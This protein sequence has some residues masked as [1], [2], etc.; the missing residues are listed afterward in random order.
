MTFLG[1][2]DKQWILAATLVFAFAF[3]RGAYTALRLRRKTSHPLML[4]LVGAG[5]VFQTIG[6]YARGM[7]YGGCPLA[8]RFELIQFLVWSAVVLYLFV[9]SSFRVSLL[10]VFISGL[11]TL[12]SVLSLII[13]SWDSADRQPIFGDS[14]WIEVHAALALFS[15]GVFGILALTSCMYL[16]QARSLKS[17][18]TG[19]LF[20]FM[21]SIVELAEING[22][23]ALIGFSILTISLAIGRVYWSREA[24]DA[25]NYAKL[26]TT[27]SVWAAYGILILL[28]WRW[29]L[30]A[31]R[32]AWTAIVF[33]L[34]ALASLQAVDQ[35][36]RQN[37]SDG[38]T[39]HHSTAP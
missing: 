29:A 18:R 17:R 28:R 6:L 24:L 38:A 30:S 36:G 1:L 14:P 16:L 2:A 4:V 11:A 37:A 3:S 5:W 12:L 27:V 21:P 8:N 25:A 10:G 22:R 35:D 23:L 34:A 19:G 13:P 7:E 31:K 9:G 20:H 26:A 32:F 15:Y 33:F 39:D